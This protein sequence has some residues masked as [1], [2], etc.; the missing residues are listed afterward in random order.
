MVEAALAVIFVIAALGLLLFLWGKKK[1][2]S[3]T[4]VSLPFA[5][6]SVSSFDGLPPVKM[7]DLLSMICIPVNPASVDSAEESARRTATPTMMVH[8]GWSLICD[9]FIHRFSAY[10]NDDEI[11]KAAPALG[12]QNVEFIQMYRGI[13]E[14]AIEH[15]GSVKSE[16]AANF[17]V[18]AP[19]L[20]ERINGGE[21]LDFSVNPE[22]K[23]ML[24]EAH[25]IVSGIDSFR[26]HEELRRSANGQI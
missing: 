20:A 15:S 25:K 6:F 5:E 17:L 22:V 13:Y 19:A 3:L 16:F 14:G 2:V 26:S 21:R 12:G 8:T 11:L 23:G 1:Q 10:P 24:F 18:R 7:F 4:R 9:A